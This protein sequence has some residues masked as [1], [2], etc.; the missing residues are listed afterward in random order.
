VNSQRLFSNPL[1]KTPSVRVADTYWVIAGK[2]KPAV[3][4]SH[5]SAKGSAFLPDGI[6]ASACEAAFI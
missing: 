3:A 1:Q 2:L 5:L 4:G 6:W